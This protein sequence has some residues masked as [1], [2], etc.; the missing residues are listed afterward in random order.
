VC[1]FDDRLEIALGA[2]CRVALPS[3]RPG[4]PTP[5]R[6]AGEIFRRFRVNPDQEDRPVKNWLVYA[7]AVV[8]LVFALAFPMRSPAAPPAP[9]PQPVPAAAPAEPHP[10]IREAIEALRS[11]RNDLNK[12]S[13]DFG[14]H[15]ADAIRTID[16]SIHQLQICLQY[17]K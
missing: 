8:A 12:A 13:H 16:E 17:D 6:L 14:G 10:H 11:A 9:K 4:A 5:S 15:R 7:F 3:G 2:D 1:F